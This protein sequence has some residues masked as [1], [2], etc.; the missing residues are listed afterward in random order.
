M[1]AQNKNAALTCPFTIILN[2]E[3]GNSSTDDLRGNLKN[4]RVNPPRVEPVEPAAE[5]K[6]FR[7]LLKKSTKTPPAPKPA[8]NKPGQIDFRNQLKNSVQTKAVTQDE[9]R[10][11]SGEQVD[12]RKSLKNNVTTKTLEQD[13]LKKM[14]PEQKD[15]REKL[16][17][18]SDSPEPSSHEPAA[19]EPS[20][21]PDTSKRPQII[22]LPAKTIECAVGDPFRIELKISGAD[23]VTWLLGND[24]VDADAEAG[25]YLDEDGENYSLRVEESMMEDRG[26]YTIIAENDH[27][28]VTC[29]ARVLVVAQ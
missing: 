10:A 19:K 13:E 11:H 16:K 27:G 7:T 4:S 18:K 2:E 17:K 14:A 28:Q 1:K 5:Q 23:K 26:L 29:Q 21:S 6:D 8:S 25:V 9:L 15:F 3:A 22:E 12:F 20:P 24:D